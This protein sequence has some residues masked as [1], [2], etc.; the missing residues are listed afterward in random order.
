MDPGHA[1]ST[2]HSL[3]PTSSLVDPRFRSSKDCGDHDLSILKLHSLDT[4]K[5]GSLAY[6]FAA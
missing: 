6:G 2:L 3:D 5:T 4:R 1:R